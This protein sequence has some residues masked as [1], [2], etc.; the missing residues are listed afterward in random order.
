MPLS[1]AEGPRHDRSL[2]C[3]HSCSRAPRCSS[4]STWTPR[5]QY[6]PTYRDLL[7]RKRSPGAASSV[8]CADGRPSSSCARS[9][10]RDGVIRR[11]V[12]A[13]RSACRRR[14]SGELMAAGGPAA[15]YVSNVENYTLPDAPTRA[16]IDNLKR[17]PHSDRSAAHPID[18]RRLL[19]SRIVPGYCAALDR[20][21]P[22]RSSPPA[23]RAGAPVRFEPLPADNASR[24]GPGARPATTCAGPEGR[25]A[26]RS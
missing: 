23:A 8:I 6:Y 5:A 18:L 9:R 12:A 24:S 25:A 22:Q 11:P 7:P 17:L 13:R 14:Q 26:C 16:Y 20:A 19:A 21:E 1:A 15:F 2:S 10:P 4:R 3:A